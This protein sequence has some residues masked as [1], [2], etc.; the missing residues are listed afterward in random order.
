[1]EWRSGH[2]KRFGACSRCGQAWEDHDPDAMDLD[3]LNEPVLNAMIR[4]A[5]RQRAGVYSAPLPSPAN[6]AP[7]REK[8]G[9]TQQRVA[10]KLRV[11]RHTVA[12]W[13]KV[14]GWDGDRE[15]PGREPSGV[16][17][18]AY[19]DLLLDLADESELSQ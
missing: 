2:W 1:M 19:S 11:S 10:D 8:A 5:E 4:T 16:V 18:A 17:R 15:L 6:R 7:I 9:W 3:H 14:A 12:K 13:E